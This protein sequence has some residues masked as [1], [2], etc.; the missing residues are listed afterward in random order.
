MNITNIYLISGLGADRRAFSKLTFPPQF[1]II[2]MDWILPKSN[3]SLPGYAIRLAEIIDQKSRFYLVGLSFGGMLATE[4][5][6]IMKPV[7]T[8]LI[9]SISTYAELPW[10][11]RAAG[12]ARLQ[13]LV[14]QKLFQNGNNIVL[15][16]LG[17]RT[18]EELALLKQLI[19]DSNPQFMKWALTCILNWRNSVRP[20][21]ITYIHGSVDMI[22]PMRY[23]MKQDYVIHQGG[24]FMVYANAGE[25]STIIAENLLL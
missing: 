17:A 8:F 18:D 1:N 24:H 5:T 9:S 6:K 16:F 23:T 3:E 2:Y 15:R 12:H 19:K 4:L 13:K 20:P 11:F 25:I 21:N 7:H 22:L 10:Y 14:P